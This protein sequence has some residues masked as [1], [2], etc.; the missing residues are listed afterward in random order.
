M[1]FIFAVTIRLPFNAVLRGKI[2]HRMTRPAG[3]LSPAK[4]KRLYE[5]FQYQATDSMIIPGGI[6]PH[7]HFERLN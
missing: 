7:T 5:D 2:A 6:D 1:S 4:V 3:R